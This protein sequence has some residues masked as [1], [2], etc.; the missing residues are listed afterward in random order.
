MRPHAMPSRRVTGFGILTLTTAATVLVTVGV[1]PAQDRPA[2]HPLAD[3]QPGPTVLFCEDFDE[4][5]PGEAA[6]PDWGVEAEQGTL[7]VA[8]GRQGQVLDVHTDGNGYAF[9]E[10][11]DFAAPDNSFFGRMWMRVDAY[12]T[13]PDWA[14]F[15]MVEATGTGDGTMVR[16]IGGQYVPDVGAPLLGVGADGGPTGDWTNWQESAPAE[17]GQWTCVEWEQDA[18]DNR[19]SVWIDGQPNPDL[20]VST[21]QH[22]GNDVDFVFPEFDTVRVGWQLYQA[23]PTPASYD[24]RFDD[25]ALATER[26]GCDA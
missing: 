1:A 4:L 7:T 10:V 11:E 25:V 16:P 14:H 23:D 15:T 21:T 22:G 20:T 12:P 13:A 6:S 9:L 24:L 17:A 19:V 5:P 2:Q 26:I 3:C 18:G 8:A